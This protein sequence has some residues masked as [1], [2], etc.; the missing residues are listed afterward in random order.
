[1]ISIIKAAAKITEELSQP[2][3]KSDANQDG[4]KHAKARLGESIKK[5]WKKTK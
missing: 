3:E 4:I 1:M 2:N 5:K